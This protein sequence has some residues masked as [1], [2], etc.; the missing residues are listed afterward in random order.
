MIWAAYPRELTHGSDKEGICCW[1]NPRG[2]GFFCPLWFHG[3][4]LSGSEAET[5]A[6]TWRS[7]RFGST[8]MGSASYQWCDLG[9]STYPLPPSIE[10]GGITISFLGLPCTVNEIPLV[11]PLTQFQGQQQQQTKHTHLVFPS[12]V[13]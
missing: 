8:L 9:Q 10:S 7:R 13:L 6:W 3:T 12:V 4:H 1:M 5:K 2:R 11:K